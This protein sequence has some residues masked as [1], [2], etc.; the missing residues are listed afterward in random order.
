MESINSNVEKE[1][2]IL[3]AES[4]I[5]LDRDID[6]Y[7]KEL[8]M[9]NLLDYSPF[10]EASEEAKTVTKTNKFIEIINKILAA[11]RRVFN[12]F[13]G[14][15]KN[16]FSGKE[17]ITAEE[18]LKSPSGQIQFEEDYQKIAEKVDE[19]VL[20][21]RKIVQAISRGTGV[22]DKVIANYCDAAAKGIQKIGIG[23][24]LGGAV[25]GI[26]KVVKNKANNVMKTVDV[27]GDELQK[28]AYKV[29]QEENKKIKLADAEN[30]FGDD[31][32]K[33]ELSK[34]KINAQESAIKVFNGMQKWATGLFNKGIKCYNTIAKY[35]K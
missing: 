16:M 15:I 13:M 29:R 5:E 33:L 3:T 22:D 27:T 21:G 26:A 7:F 20:K 4:N 24:V 17:D 32:D 31:P 34:M 18:Y 25:M 30:K 11:V 8:E 35:S 9:L 2:Y 1:M 19:E 10:C 28:A 6:Q 23:V 12:S 14:M